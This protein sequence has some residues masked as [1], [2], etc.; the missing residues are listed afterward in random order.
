MTYYIHTTST[1]YYSS[2]IFHVN[3][4]FCYF[5]LVVENYY[6]NKYANLKKTYKAS[7]NTSKEKKLKKVVVNGGSYNDIEE[8]RATNE[9]RN[10]S[11]SRTENSLT[12]LISDTDTGEDLSNDKFK[13][14]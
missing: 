13:K 2:Q 12:N 3:P 6:R 7:A 1:E 8:S 4:E 14:E 5:I 9:Q 10:Y 11:N